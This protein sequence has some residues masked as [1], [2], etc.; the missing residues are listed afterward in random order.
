MNSAA[1]IVL[2]IAGI[3]LILFIS[4]ALAPDLIA[5]MVLCGLGI[6]GILNLP[7]LLSGFGSPVIVTLIGLFIIT[8]ALNHTGVTA[9]LS[10]RLLTL[11]QERSEHT[12]VGVMSLA[13]G[14][15][16]L[17]MNTVASV[18]L[19]APVGRRIAFRRSLSP[20]L[21]LMP[22]AY[23]ALLGGMA[24]LLTTSNLLLSTMLVDRDL[25]ALTLFSFLP[26][27]GP[28]ALMGIGYLTLLS[29]RLLPQRSPMD[30]WTALQETRQELT[31]TYVLG[32]R[33][34]EA[35]VRP[36]SPLVGTLLS[37]SNLGH[38][39][40]LTACAVVQGRTRHVPPNPTMPIQLHD[41][42]LVSGRPDDI[43]RAAES[44]NLAISDPAESDLQLLYANDNELAEV[45]LSPHTNL[46]GQTLGE[47]AFRDKYG[48]NV[49]AMWHEGRAIRSH[50]NEYPLA[51]GDAL[52]VQGT[53]DRLNILNRE[54]DFLVLT[55]LPEIPRGSKNAPIALGIL[56]VFLVLVGT[57]LLPTALA[58]LVC[59]I[60]VVVTG[61]ET[62]E[63]ARASVQ[64]Q[65]IF[66]IAGM[67]PM[68]KALE[69]TGITDSLAGSIPHLL[70]LV[71]LHGLVLLVFAL[72]VGLTQLTSGPAAVLI[73]GPTMIAVALHNG[74]NP[75]AMAVTM[76]IGASTA[77]LSPIAHAANLMV[78]GPGGYRFIDYGRLGLP[79]VILAGLGVLILVP[80]VYPF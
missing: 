42:L 53:P 52:L 37:K 5:L 34:F 38:D 45:A 77:F 58:A 71:G 19:I 3:A 33:L 6:G 15:A 61:C 65:V 80:L 78:M 44:L 12:L 11:T 51:R 68:A 56:L 63:Q 59:G 62:I 50:L 64:W 20:S 54:P 29:A 17:M 26:V 49:L 75:Q 74:L 40:G 14:M 4:E 30:E 60:A 2:A 24:T 41:L 47:I 36:G 57:S 39:Y 21:L 69:A 7:A 73:I 32:T 43:V 70:S 31:K 8:S 9:Y 27:G 76:G 66:L 67:L 55:Q 79:L 16:S 18:A 48:I 13:A 1:I 10:Q 35:E 72:T 28:I 22:I 23:G 46:A 25:P